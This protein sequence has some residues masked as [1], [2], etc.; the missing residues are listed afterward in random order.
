[1]KKNIKILSLLSVLLIAI[2]GCSS[3]DSETPEVDL[4]GKVFYGIV[5]AS[6]NPASTTNLTPDEYVLMSFSDEN[7]NEISYQPK[8]NT[9]YR[10][11]NG[12]LCTWAK[13]GSDVTPKDSP[14]SFDFLP[15]EYN[16]PCQ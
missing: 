8:P 7:G 16:A 11:C 3:S 2:F 12:N 15:N 4:K 6:C 10:M 5:V 14:M 13:T 1:M 9:W